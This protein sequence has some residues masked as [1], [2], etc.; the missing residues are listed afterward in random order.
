MWEMRGEQLRCVE[1]R[2]VPGP[3]RAAPRNLQHLSLNPST[4]NLHLH[5]H[6][7]RT[8][9]V[10]EWSTAIPF[11]IS[12]R[13]EQIETLQ[14]TLARVPWSPPPHCFFQP[15][16]AA[17]TLQT[18]H[19]CNPASKGRCHRPS[20]LHGARPLEPGQRNSQLVARSDQVRPP[21]R[22]MSPVRS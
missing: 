3:Q 22:D 1:V 11:G 9:T 12:P 8:G 4:L 10:N 21:T 17:S 15:S 14:F 2:E 6:W 19:E 13:P 7:Q 20:P 18:G 5:L 16:S